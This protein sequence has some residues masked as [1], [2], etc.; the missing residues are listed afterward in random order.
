MIV[1]FVSSL[2]DASE[3]LGICEGCLQTATVRP[4]DGK[5]VS[6]DRILVVKFLEPKRWDLIAFKWPEEP[7]VEYVKRLVGLP[8]EEIAI[9]D[10]ELMIDGKAA[11]KPPEIAALT[12]VADPFP[13]GKATWGPVRLADDEYFVLGDFSRSSMDSRNWH[14][15]AEGHPPYAV[16]ASHIVGVLT[17][18]YWPISRWRSF[19]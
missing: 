5:P 11:K 13:E 17:H 7:T 6:G 14:R 18:I 19:R 4:L 8:G 10:G 9:R 3:T 1:P 12:Y 2:H 15:G 16:P